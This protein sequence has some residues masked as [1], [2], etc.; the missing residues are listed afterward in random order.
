MPVA[1]GL[2]YF[3]D[4]PLLRLGILLVPPRDEHLHL[5]PPV[6]GRYQGPSLILVREAGG[7]LQAGHAVPTL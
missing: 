4:R 6:N 3:N 1:V 2:F 5:S 7:G